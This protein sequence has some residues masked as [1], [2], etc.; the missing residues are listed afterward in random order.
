MNQPKIIEE[1]KA[2][3]ETFIT[4]DSALGDSLWHIFLE[5]HPVD[6]A[7]FLSQISRDDVERVFMR[8]PK[9]ER[10]AVF[11][12]L[13]DVGKAYC[14]TFMGEQDKVEALQALSVD[15]LTDLFDQVSDEDLKKYLNL[16]HRRAREK[17]ISLLQ[18]HPESA[19]GIMET[20]VLTL[21]EDFTVEK[22]ITMLQRLRPRRE[23]H[24]QIYVTNSDHQLVGHINLE[25][26]VL[27]SPKVRISSFLR[28]NEL[29]VHADED[30]EVIAKQMVHYS[31]MSVPVVGDENYFL[32]V[33]PSGILVDVLVQE[34][35]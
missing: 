14:L 27:Q 20:E 7:D 17:V 2:N 1:I 12:E 6:I 13:S 24:Q 30:Q 32:G 26:L 23:V 16:L 22:S 19:G 31:L 34:A 35:S 8:L 4:R 21:M 29:T 10:L 11:G 9:T 5:L 18:F 3:L 25:D 15:S 28:K 33:I